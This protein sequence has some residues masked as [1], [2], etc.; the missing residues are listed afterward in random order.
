MEKENIAKSNL[1]IKEVFRVIRSGHKVYRRTITVNNRHSDAFVF[2]LSGS[3]I[4]TVDE[5][6]MTAG[7]GDILFLACGADYHMYVDDDQ[8]RYIFCDFEFAWDKP[9]K[10]MVFR[11][12]NPAFAESLFVKLLSTYK[13]GAPNADLLSVL[14]SIYGVVIKSQSHVY[15]EKT[16]RLTVE[17]AK[18]RI[19]T[20]YMDLELSVS[21]LA[22]QADMSE[23]YFRK[24]FKA[25][26][27]QSPI[28]YILSVML[29]KARELM[30]YPFLSLEECAMQSGFA[31]QQY[32]CKLFK[33]HV[34]M[35]PACYRK[36]LKI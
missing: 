16:K 8:Y 10:C 25:E 15:V 4:Y 20:S 17:E 26:L 29:G 5:R 1:Y 22:R 9:R 30:R 14:Y 28:Q 21:S 11:T 13:S 32:F 6:T 33:K 35:T 23:V 3:C 31:S 24:L 7:Q 36:S 12:E 27:G 34:G 19:D 2:V 18:R